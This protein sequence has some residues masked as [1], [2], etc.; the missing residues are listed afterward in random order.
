MNLGFCV[1]Q[2]LSW[3]DFGIPEIVSFVAMR[4]KCFKIAD[5]RTM[6]ALNRRKLAIK[7]G[8]CEQGKVLLLG[9]ES[10]ITVRAGRTTIEM[11]DE[12]CEAQARST[13]LPIEAEDAGVSICLIVSTRLNRGAAA[14]GAWP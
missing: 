10:L 4:E 9:K 7:P 6:A 2:I 12:L 14:S 5:A 13:D 1:D 11:I 3:C 8:D